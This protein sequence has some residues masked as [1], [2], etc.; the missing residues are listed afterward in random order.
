MIKKRFLFIKKIYEK[1]KNKKINI[2]FKLPTKADV[3]IYGEA[4]EEMIRDY[5]PSS[6]KIFLIKTWELIFYL[7]PIIIF[8]TLRNLF[9]KQ[10]IF[11]I[12]IDGLK[13]GFLMYFKDSLEEAIINHIK[14]K[15]VIT[16]IDNSTRFGRLSS[17]FNKIRFI[18]I[19]NGCRS[20]WDT[21]DACRHDIYL[22]F[23]NQEANMLQKLGWE[24]KVAKNIGSLNAAR[25]FK[26]LKNQK[27]KKDLLIISCWRGNVEI[28]FDYLEQ[29]KAMTEM[30]VFLNSLINKENYSA[31]II[32]R[33]KR[34]DQHW[35]IKKFNLNEEQYYRNI[36][37][38]SCEI[39]E[40]KKYNKK[41]GKDVYEEIHGSH[42][43]VSFLT[44]AILEGYI[45]GYNCVYLNFYKNDFYH[46][47]FPKELVLPAKNKM[48][49]ESEIKKRIK[50]SAKRSND[51][52]L[53]S[54]TK[55]KYT[56]NKFKSILNEIIK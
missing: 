7:E 52:S 10:L 6:K 16:Y 22:T 50:D 3:I 23:T 24:I 49:L 19:Q 38:N 45:Y 56:L 28:D 30:H 11:S 29:F 44:T 2:I 37:G 43:S 55:S 5:L 9:K 13:R 17:K 39:V 26:N 54:K 14:P 36:Y 48:Q 31:R 18:A 35:F 4:R 12:F 20:R 53:L 32:L 33:S 1:L 21:K 42:L 25:E 40:N 51:I 8:N 46:Q 34:D 41:I 27:S 15:L 47:D